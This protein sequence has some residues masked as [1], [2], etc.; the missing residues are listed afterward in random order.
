MIPYL[1]VQNYSI[2]IELLDQNS[3]LLNI[4]NFYSPFYG[5]FAD[6]VMV[7]VQHVHSQYTTP[8]KA[9]PTSKVI[10]TDSWKDS[11]RLY[12]MRVVLT[13]F[14]LATLITQNFSRSLVVQHLEHSKSYL[15]VVRPAKKVQ[16]ELL[17]N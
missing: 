6:H 7:E 4:S 13:F 1:A 15:F 3:A 8:Q 9:A 16:K 2:A 12:F 17:S 10:Y 14:C 11:M 5:E